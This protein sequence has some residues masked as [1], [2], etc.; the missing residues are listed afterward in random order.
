VLTTYPEQSRKSGRDHGSAATWLDL[1]DPNDE[2]LERAAKLLGDDLP[3]REQVSAQ[4][5]RFNSF[6]TGAGNGGQ[7][8][9]TWQ[10]DGTN[11]VVQWNIWNNLR[12][13]GRIDPTTGALHLEKMGTL[14][15]GATLEF[16]RQ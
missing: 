15:D 2:E 7:T 9:G 12:C 8:F 5:E 16:K 10:S 11:V 4:L 14:N 13:N 3:T 6:R 1:V